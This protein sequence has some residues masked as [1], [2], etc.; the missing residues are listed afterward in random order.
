MADTSMVIN[1]VADLAKLRRT[2][3][4]EDLY[5]LAP[6]AEDGNANK[7]TVSRF[8][9]TIQD[10]GLWCEW[11]KGV[12]C[13]CRRADTKQP[14]VNCQ[15]CNGIGHFYPPERRE[16][17][18]VLILG[19][20]PKGD[21]K[22]PGVLVTGQV[23]L[24]F[25]SKYDPHGGDM[26]FPEIEYHH[27]DQLLVRASNQ[28]VKADVVDRLSSSLAMLPKQT[29]R[30]E[31]LRYQSGIDVEW[32]GWVVDGDD[33]GKRVAKASVGV[34]FDLFGNEIRWKEG[35]GPEAG[36]TYSVHYT[37]PAA[38]LITE[39]S[40]RAAEN[41]ILNRSLTGIRLDQWDPT[42]DRR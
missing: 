6:L 13:P 14:N 33:G 42:G 23:G 5:G 36:A 25:E 38:Y 11:R 4:T 2:G 19:R 20:R 7:I 15:E 40:F 21:A 39:D 24:T 1:G 9:R 10:R 34:D 32:V 26:V 17:V 27:V 31:R 3:P 8:D 37:A 28:V 41:I 12:L 29:P 22:D 35:R 18:K 16:R 30:P